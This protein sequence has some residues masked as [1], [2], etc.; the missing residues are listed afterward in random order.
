M[1]MKKIFADIM[2]FCV[3]AGALLPVERNSNNTMTASAEGET[4]DY[5]EGTYELLTYE[6]YGDYIEI[7]GCDE[8]ATEV[9]IPA[10]IEGLPVTSIGD[11]AFY[12]CVNLTSVTIPDSVT[13][14]GGSAFHGCVK[15]TSVMIPSSLTSIE[16]GVFSGCSGLTS[17]TI[18]D[19]VTSIGG[20]AFSG[21]SGLTSVTIPASVTYIGD[22][23]FGNCSG[24]DF[25]NNT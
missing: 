5:T 10:E 16:V 7:S 24:L 6:N 21:C 3:I 17:V 25:V 9:E 22:Y 13:S 8:T 1:N 12:D 14:I 15:L 20:F 18:P 23:A 2:A 4:A 11:S 19:S